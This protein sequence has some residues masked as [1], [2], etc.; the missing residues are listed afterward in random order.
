MSTTP[1][2]NENTEE[3]V[4]EAQ[5]IAV[6]E[7]AQVINQVYEDIFNPIEWTV[8]DE[9]NNLLTMDVS[10]NVEIPN[11]ADIIDFTPAEILSNLEND[12]A[13][14]GEFQAEKSVN[15]SPDKQGILSV[16]YVNIMKFSDQ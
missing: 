3:E 9:N 4:L 8:N 6:Q 14:S 16:I 13:A 2:N 10:G 7:A 15:V 5:R 1:N 12:T 11:I